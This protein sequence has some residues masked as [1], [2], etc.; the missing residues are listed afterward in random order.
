MKF[1]ILTS[2]QHILLTNTAIISRLV[3]LVVAPG[4]KL[5]VDS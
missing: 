2:C 1:Q 5:S 3:F 4:M